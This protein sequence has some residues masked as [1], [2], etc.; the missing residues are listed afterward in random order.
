MRIIS[1]LLTAWALAAASPAQAGQWAMVGDQGDKG[2]RSIFYA[3][4]DLAHNRTDLS[5]SGVPVPGKTSKSR[6]DLPPSPF[7]NA[8]VSAVEVL[9]IFEAADRQANTMY[10]VVVD[11]LR[12]RMKLTQIESLFRDGKGISQPSPDTDW[13]STPQSVW[14]HN[15]RTI[16]CDRKGNDAA[17]KESVRIQAADPLMELGLMPVGDFGM[18]FT[19]PLRELTFSVFWP[20][21]VEP[22]FAKMTATEERELRERIDVNLANYK[23]TLESFTK[24]AETSLGEQ[25]SERQF[26][27]DIRSTFA[28]KAKRPR[29][30]FYNMEGWTEDLVTG[31]W[32]PPTATSQHGSITAFEYYA[33]VDNRETY[34]EQQIETDQKGLA[35][36]MQE[37]VREVG[38]PQFC[39]MTL[40]LKPGGSKPGLRL[41]DYDIRGDNCKRST[42]ATLTR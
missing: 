9:Q 17:I 22:P 15:V 6:D 36:H 13:F 31:L 40:F 20:D 42:L 7:E 4:Y 1:L 12:D 37:V 30:L 41:I 23:Q 11:C 28:K 2:D 32:G 10:T 16:A 38:E 3:R 27:A 25:D 26:L 8:E 21:A 34:I 18:F 24:L 14:L 19:G 35:I 33:T 29:R 5:L 39:A